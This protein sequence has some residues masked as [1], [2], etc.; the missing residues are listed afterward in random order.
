MFLAELFIIM[1]S[2]HFTR[3]IRLFT[4]PNPS[5]P[6][7]QQPLNFN[8]RALKKPLRVACI[9]DSITAG[10]K[11]LGPNTS[12][13]SQLQ[14]LLGN[15]YEVQNFGV[16]GARVLRKCGNIPAKE[17][18]KHAYFLMEKYHEALA[19]LPDIAVVQ[20]GTNDAQN[21]FLP[22]FNAFERDYGVM[23]DMLRNLSSQPEVH[24]MVP[25]PLFMDGFHGLN[26]TVI[27]N[28]LP[29]L[30]RKIATTKGLPPPIDNFK[31]FTMQCPSY[32]KNVGRKSYMYDRRDCKLIYDGC[33]PTAIGY[34]KIAELVHEAIIN[35]N[36]TFH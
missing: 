7:V 4:N 34:T 33:H 19:F 17:M 6:L 18:R 2:L 26:Q 12:Y 9:G 30:V 16:S 1:S 15:G 23:I 31:S 24:I 22:C 36:R 27:Q 21:R 20:L 28:V 13:P 3:A 10:Q 11:H 29:P 25:P 8:A 14:K 5:V 32:S 35:S